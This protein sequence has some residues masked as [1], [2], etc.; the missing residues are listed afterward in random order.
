[1]VHLLGMNIPPH[2]ALGQALG[3]ASRP[4][5]SVRVVEATLAVLAVLA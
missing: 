3:V 4:D 2:C 1:M 5:Y